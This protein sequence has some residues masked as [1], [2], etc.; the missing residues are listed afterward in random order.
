LNARL[1]RWL[2]AAAVAAAAIFAF[3]GSSRTP[4]PVTRGS[5]AP[6]FTLPRLDGD[7]EISLSSQRG[8]VVLLNFWAT[9]CAPCEQEMPAMQRLHE[10]LGDA[11]FD[12]LAVSVDT[13]ESDVRA[14]RDRLGLTF[15]ILLDPEHASSARYQTFRYPESFLI[16]RKG[17][18]VE[19]YVG[20]RDWD[21]PLYLDHIRELLGQ[22]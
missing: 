14:F 21:E 16:D 6:D 17:V 1:G 18:V 12:L 11:G 13:S 7:G 22:S 5:A 19:R 10:K 4:P 9:W 3:Y 8:R 15:P 2:V 20:P